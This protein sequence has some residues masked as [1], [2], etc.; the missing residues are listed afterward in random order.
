MNVNSNGPVVGSGNSQ[1]TCQHFESGMIVAIAIIVNMM[2]CPH[3]KHVV[4]EYE[5]SFF[6]NS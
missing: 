5:Y 4:S 2:F 6:A 1:F 3:S